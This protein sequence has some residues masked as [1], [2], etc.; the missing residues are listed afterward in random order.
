MARALNKNRI[1]HSWLVALVSLALII[2]TRA[3]FTPQEQWHEVLELVGY[4][5]VLV[6]ALGRIYTTAFLGGFKNVA[7]ID[8]GPFSVVRNPLYLFSL[9]GIL[10][11]CLISLHLPVMLFAPVAV[12][13]IY[14]FLI[15]REEEYLAEKMGQP[16][17]EYCARTPRF[18]P[19]FSLYRMPE[20]IPVNPRQIQ[21]AVLDA[22]WW[23]IPFPLFEILDL[24]QLS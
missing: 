24:I 16:Y 21:R 12:F 5:L 3:L 2:F 9:S 10:G 15:R 19:D 11:I 7:V 18:I 1:R 8:Y 20:T 23:F 13:F 14:Y 17:E 22:F 6:C 4:M